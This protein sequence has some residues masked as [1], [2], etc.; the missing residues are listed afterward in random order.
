MLVTPGVF[1]NSFSAPQKQPRAKYA[2]SEPSGTL[3]TGMP[4][5]SWNVGLTS[6]D[7]VRPRRACSGSTRVDFVRE[8]NMCVSLPLCTALTEPRAVTQRVTHGPGLFRPR[9]TARGLGRSSPRRLA[10]MTETSGFSTR[11]IH[12]GQEPD[13][14]TG[15]VVPPIYATSTYIQDGVGGTTRRV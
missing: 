12:A 3:C 14:A 11:A 5:M 4:K 9:W 15:S 7:E 8:K 13:P 1:Q 6:T 2:T 10:G